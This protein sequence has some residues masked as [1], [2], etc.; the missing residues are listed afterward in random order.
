MAFGSR[1]ATFCGES[2]LAEDEENSDDDGAPTRLTPIL[3][4][5]DTSKEEHSF[6]FRSSAIAQ[7]L[8]GLIVV[9][10]EDAVRRRLRDVEDGCE[11]SSHR[12][13]Q[14][15]WYSSLLLWRGSK[16]EPIRRPRL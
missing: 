10:E 3:L 5:T 11:D 7:K 13:S 12:K 14:V 15:I 4:C 6:V 16:D 1:G 2:V 9:L 8:V